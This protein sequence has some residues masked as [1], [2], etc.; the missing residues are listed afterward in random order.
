MSKTNKD[1]VYASF[2]ERIGA[3]FIDTI[4]LGLFYYLFL[5][6][7]KN[8]LSDLIGPFNFFIIENDDD[9]NFIHPN[10]SGLLIIQY[11]IPFFLAFFYSAI[12]DSSQHQGTIGKQ[13]L[14][15]KVVEEDLK[16]ISFSKSC[17]RSFVNMFS[18]FFLLGYFYLIFEKKKQTF[19]DE[20]VGTYVIK[21][22]N[23]SS[24]NSLNKHKNINQILTIIT[25][26]GLITILFFLSF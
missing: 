18:R 22:K 2:W 11:V 8:Q 1:V 3:L 6:I 10:Y 9:I 12:L 20:M 23:I 4:I 13:S 26:I 7:F 25:V 24:I 14:N 19:H 21:M 17:V 15:L 5:L 16:R